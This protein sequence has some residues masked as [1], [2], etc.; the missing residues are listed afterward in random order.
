MNFTDDSG[1][2]GTDAVTVAEEISVAHSTIIPITLLSVTIDQ[3]VGQI[4][5]TSNPTIIFMAEFSESVQSGT[6]DC[7][8]I[9]VTNGSCTSV[10]DVSSTMYTVNVTGATSGV[11]TASVIAGGVLN[12]V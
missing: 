8:D 1:N 5:P 7:T 4:D 6:V 10:V 12:T 11:V 9:S 3:A 2:V